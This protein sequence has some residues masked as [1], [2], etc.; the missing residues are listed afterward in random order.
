MQVGSL[1]D[2]FSLVSF[3]PLNITEED[4]LH[5]ILLQIDMAIQYGEDEEVRSRDGDEEE[6]GDD[7]D[8]DWGED[9]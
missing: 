3:L 6:E 1:L 2:D 7:D 5:E 4:S 8:Q 9:D